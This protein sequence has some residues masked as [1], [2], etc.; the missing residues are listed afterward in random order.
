MGRMI[1]GE[2]YPRHCVRCDIKGVFGGPMFK[3]GRDNRLYCSVCFNELLT[4]NRSF[5]KDGPY[6]DVYPTYI[7]GESPIRRK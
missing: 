2:R 6:V 3:L 7:Y 1:I 4:L 5:E